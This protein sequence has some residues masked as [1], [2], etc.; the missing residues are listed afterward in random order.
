LTVGI[1]IS[2][3]AAINFCVSQTVSSATLTSMPSSPACRV[4]IKNSAVL[5]R[6]W[7]LL[8]F[9][10]ADLLTS[11]RSWINASPAEQ[12]RTPFFGKPYFC[13]LLQ[14]LSG[15]VISSN[16]A[17]GPFGY[18]HQIDDGPRFLVL[19]KNFA[20]VP[21]DSQPEDIPKC[22]SIRKIGGAFGIKSVFMI[23]EKA[24]FHFIIVA[25]SP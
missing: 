8:S 15:M 17:V 11:L 24:S 25:N 21:T 13:L 3:S 2:N 22:G 23:T 12:E 5:L 10:M 16:P 19:V 4:N 7:S 1:V 18:F 20:L 6:I 9:F 14:G